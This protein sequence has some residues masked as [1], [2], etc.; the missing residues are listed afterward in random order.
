MNPQ[1]NC[2]YDLQYLDRTEEKIKQERERYRQD[3]GK[4]IC[5]CNKCEVQN[6]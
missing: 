4:E 6:D 2:L 1:E 3:N 5:Y